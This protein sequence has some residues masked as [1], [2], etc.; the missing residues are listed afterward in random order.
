MN[1]PAPVLAVPAQVDKDEVRLRR[2]VGLR[3]DEYWLNL[4]NVT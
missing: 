3:K 1:D 2:T 4:K